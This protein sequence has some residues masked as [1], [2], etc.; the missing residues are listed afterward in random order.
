MLTPFDPGEVHS[1]WHPLFSANLNEINQILENIHPSECTPARRNIFR[2]FQEPLD[3]VRVLIVG[4]D[5]YP[6]DGVADG[7]AFS[8][9][10]E[11]QVIPASLRNIFKEYVEDLSLPTPASGDLTPWSSKGVMLL[12]RSLTT[13]VGFRNAHSQNGWL[14]FTENVARLLSER[15]VV[16]I[17]W[18]SYAQK[19]SPL[20]SHRLCS[21]HPSPLSAYRGFFGSK[22]F[23]R[24]N[25]VLVSLGK[26][27]IDWHL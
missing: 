15:D 17:L 14:N 21:P 13:S 24:A 4:Q 16:A 25:E 27:E 18:G 22:P 5:P 23:S 10:P 9:Q 11:N 8:V 26:P 6:G 12:N 3:S 2:V 19:L 20:F 7:L 1:S